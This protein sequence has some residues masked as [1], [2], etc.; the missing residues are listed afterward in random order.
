MD[1]NVR[2][3]FQRQEN[4]GESHHYFNGFATR[5][6]VDFSNLSDAPPPPQEPDPSSFLP[7]K[8]D[9]CSMKDELTVLVAR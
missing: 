1:K 5:D 2:P 3:R 9:L 7:S 6:R 4:K 8:Q